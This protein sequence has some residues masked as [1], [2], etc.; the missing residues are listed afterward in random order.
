MCRI[1]PATSVICNREKDICCKT[2]PA[3]SVIW[4]REKDICCKTLPATSV[5]WNRRQ[6]CSNKENWTK[7]LNNLT[8]SFSLLF[9]TSSPVGLEWGLDSGGW[10]VQCFEQND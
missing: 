5:I 9:W 7:E 4:N 2:L 6:I 3:T 10:G 1:L 8:Y